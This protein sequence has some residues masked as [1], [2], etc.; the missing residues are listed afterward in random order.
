MLALTG[1][2]MSRQEVE[3]LA[4]ALPQCEIDMVDEATT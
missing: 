4:R 1:S 3:Q 2:R